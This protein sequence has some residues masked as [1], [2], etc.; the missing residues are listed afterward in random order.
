MKNTTENST[1]L[2]RQ[3]LGLKILLWF[4]AFMIVGGAICIILGALKWAIQSAI[5]V[6]A[7]LLVIGLLFTVAYQSLRRKIN[8]ARKEHIEHEEE[9]HQLEDHRE[10]YKALNSPD[11]EKGN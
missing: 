3:P 1:G 9:K 6:G 2:E 7:V 11:K 5:V 4:T 8:Q 10:Q